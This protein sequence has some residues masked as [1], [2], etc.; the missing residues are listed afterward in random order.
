MKIRFGLFAVLTLSITGAAAGTAT[1]SINWLDA[2]QDDTGLVW[3]VPL[4][5]GKSVFIHDGSTWKELNWTPPASNGKARP[6]AITAGSDGLVRI[7][8]RGQDGATHWLTQHRGS[9]YAIVAQFSA[10][11]ETPEFKEPFLFV[12]SK[13][14]VWITHRGPT[15]LRVTE[16]AG[17]TEAYAIPQEHLDDKGRRHF[18][19]APHAIEDGH[20]HVWF[21]LD[22]TSNNVITANGFVEFDGR[23]FAFRT[24]SGLP[25]DGSCRLLQ[26]EDRDHLLAAFR[27]GLFRIDV[28]NYS[29]TPVDQ[30]E[31]R[32]FAEISQIFAIGETRY[33]VARHPS[34]S[35]TE[36]SAV[37]RWR[38]GES[39]KM[40]AHGYDRLP[41]F[42]PNPWLALPNG[43]ILGTAGAGVVFLPDQ[44]EMQRLDWKNNV[45]VR[46]P[47][48]IFRMPANNILLVGEGSTVAPLPPWSAPAQNAGFEEIPGKTGL[49]PDSRNHVW[50]IDQNTKEIQEWN[51][52]E[53]TTVPVLPD[54]KWFE[55][56]MID[57]HDRLWVTGRGHGP[58]V[59]DYT[60]RRWTNW[61]GDREPIEQYVHEDPKFTVGHHSVWRL[62]SSGEGRALRRYGAAGSADYFDGKEWK[63]W[64]S[65]ELPHGYP[66]FAPGGEPMLVT[67]TE[68]FALRGDNWVPANGDDFPG[69]RP[70]VDGDAA[71]SVV[72][73]NDGQNVVMD[74]SGRAWSTS[75]HQLYLTRGNKPEPV[76]REGESNPFMDGRSLMDVV[77][78]CDSNVFLQTNAGFGNW[79]LLRAASI[80]R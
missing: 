37:W 36:G 35:L 58:Y 56:L 33:V 63:S 64:R 71:D 38:G 70:K 28:T 3:G 7:V 62:V 80:P 69:N 6:V 21:W 26:T 12:D 55:S 76:F 61:P 14:N 50:A 49:V 30:P 65:A 73:R 59:W 52:R 46:T 48:R 45:Q 5:N 68:I 78:D 66:R 42:F 32:A 2:A 74:Q 13:R 15:I 18:F 40:I 9:N 11:F 31:N 53:W 1:D 20:G 22:G 25:N 75:Q 44:G 77:V 54:M 8:W 57:N 60:V 47:R 24:I 10:K 67:R 72:A 41:G 27:H 34:F 17:V 29:A 51:G 19:N 39:P 79:V 23:N 4:N 43:L 16:N